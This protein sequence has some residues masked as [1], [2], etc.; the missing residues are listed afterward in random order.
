MSK[1]PMRLAILSRNKN[2]HSIRRLLAEA[3]KFRN[4]AI[5]CDVI[6]PLECQL[7][8][9]GLT[10]GSG[11]IVGAQPLPDYDCVLPRIG[12]SITDYG[13]AVVRQFETLGVC[14]VNGTRAIAESRDKM[15]CLQILSEAGIRVPASVL[16]RS[17]RGFRTAIE[18]VGGLPVVMKVLQGTQGRG[19][20]LLNAP[21]SL[22]TV[23]ETLQSLE[24]DVIIQ[25]FIAEGAGRDYR[26]FVIGNQVVAAM[27]R[28]APEGEFRSNI[29]RG[30]EG[31]LVKLPK[32]FERTAIRAT[33]ALG[34]E[35][36]GVD[37]MESRGGPKVLEV[38]SSPGFEGIERATGLNI[39]AMIIRHIARRHRLRRGSRR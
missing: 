16:T 7:V 38:N 18:S 14:V 15:R 4:P 28:T 22:A 13:L 25:Q 2:L 26:A 12:A 32:A 31:T 29:H 9:N 3:R 1:A 8:L 19:V 30:G 39:A 27:L 5:R 20:M 23:H 10:R 11:I 21:I 24:Q 34:L 35:I 33:R 6:N 17:Q 36:A 37:L